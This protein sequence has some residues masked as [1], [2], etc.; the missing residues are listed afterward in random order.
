M[1]RINGD[2][3]ATGEL[4]KEEKRRNEVMQMCLQ[5]PEGMKKVFS[6]GRVAH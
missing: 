3:R 6:S 4:S 5:D 2:S 1:L